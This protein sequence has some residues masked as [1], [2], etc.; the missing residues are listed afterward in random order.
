MDVS[1]SEVDK[2]NV[3]KA[4]AL[5]PVLLCLK[6]EKSYY[7]TRNVK[8]DRTEEISVR[9]NQSEGNEFDIRNAEEYKSND[10][11][12]HH[13]D[14]CLFQSKEHEK[15]LAEGDK[16]PGFNLKEYLEETGKSY[17]R[18]HSK[19]NE[20]ISLY[21]YIR[22]SKS[23]VTVNKLKPSTQ[24]KKPTMNSIDARTTQSSPIGKIKS[25]T[26]SSG[27]EKH[28]R[29]YTGE[30]TCYTSRIRKSRESGKGKLSKSN[31]GLT[32]GPVVAVLNKSKKMLFN[33]QT[34][35]ANKRMLPIMRRADVRKNSKQAATKR[36]LCAKC[37]QLMV[38]GFAVNNCECRK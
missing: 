13:L 17:Q 14:N 37:I 36:K 21:N 33:V 15:S 16:A 29:S 24:S 18:S 38:Q 23:T 25:S 6:N 12:Q 19:E 22:Q 32:L 35:L 7:E 10:L 20:N 1:E 9:S 4:R 34:E 8:N 31:N 3:D 26:K 5:H 27:V 30:Q 2:E 28:R 11:Y